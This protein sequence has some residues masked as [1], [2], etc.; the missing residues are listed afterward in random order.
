MEKELKDVT[1]Y[2]TIVDKVADFVYN[3]IAA[4]HKMF[5]TTQF[6]YIGEKLQNEKIQVLFNNI[7]GYLTERQK[8]EFPAT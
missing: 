2:L 8:N 5:I 7:F 6:Y 1:W 3:R 4:P